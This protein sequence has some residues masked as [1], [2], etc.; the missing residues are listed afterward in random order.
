MSTAVETLYGSWMDAAT[1]GQKEEVFGFDP[2]AVR[3]RWEIRAEQA[4]QEEEEMMGFGDRS[5]GD[6]DRGAKEYVPVTAAA[7][8]ESITAPGVKPSWNT[9][10]DPVRLQKPAHVKLRT[11]E[12]LAREAE[13]HEVFA[14]QL[15]D[16]MEQQEQQREAEL[17]QGRW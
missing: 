9:T 16:L 5:G 7:A 17:K 11:A 6:G 1:G 10:P 4:K 14:N 2:A 3:G 12:E 15:F 13:E 8:L